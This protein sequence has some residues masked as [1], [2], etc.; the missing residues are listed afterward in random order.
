MKLRVLASR[1]PSAINRYPD[2]AQEKSE[3]A[4]SEDNKDQKNDEDPEGGADWERKQ[5]ASGGIPSD[6]GNRL[7]GGGRSGNAKIDKFQGY[8]TPPMY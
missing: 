2:E 7:P 6:K 8:K 5:A 4:E 3:N 1:N